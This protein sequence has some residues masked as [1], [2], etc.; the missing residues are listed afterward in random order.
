MDNFDFYEQILK[1][2][3]YEE[4]YKRISKEYCEKKC[5]SDKDHFVNQKEDSSFDEEELNIRHHDQ[6]ENDQD[7]FG[8]LDLVKLGSL[9]F[10]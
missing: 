6:D 1:F 7:E 8:Q 10:F 2:L 5:I 4:R 3:E 9:V